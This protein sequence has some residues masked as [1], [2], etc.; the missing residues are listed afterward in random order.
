MLWEACFHVLSCNWRIIPGHYAV[1]DEGFSQMTCHGCTYQGPFLKAAKLRSVFRAAVDRTVHL[2]PWVLE[3][4]VAVTCMSSSREFP[5]HWAVGSGSSPPPD[6]VRPVSFVTSEHYAHQLCARVRFCLRCCL[7]CTFP[8]ETAW[9]VVPYGT[10]ASVPKRGIGGSGSSTLPFPFPYQDLTPPSSFDEVFARM[11]LHS[12]MCMGCFLLPL[13]RS[14]SGMVFL[15]LLATM[16]RSVPGKRT[17]LGSLIGL[18]FK[19]TSLRVLVPLGQVGVTYT[20]C[21]AAKGRRQMPCSLR[22]ATRG[23]RTSQRMLDPPPFR[24]AGYTVPE[25]MWAAP[26][27]LPQ[28]PFLASL[29][30]DMCPDEL[31]FQ[32]HSRRDDRAEVMQGSGVVMTGCPDPALLPQLEFP[33]LI[34]PAAREIVAPSHLAAPEEQAEPT[35]CVIQVFVPQ[36]MARIVTVHLALPVPLDDLQEEVRRDLLGPPFDYGFVLKPTAPQVGEGYVSLVAGGPW[37]EH[38]GLVVVV[39]DMQY[40]GGPTFADYLHIHADYKD[41]EVVARRQGLQ[42]WQAF[43]AGNNEKIR[44]RGVFRPSF[45]AVVQFR[46]STESVSWPSSIHPRLADPR[47]WSTTPVIAGEG[48]ASSALILGGEAGLTC[49]W[50]LDDETALDAVML[51]TFSRPRDCLTIV[52]PHTDALQDVVFQ[53]TACRQV[54]AV[55]GATNAACSQEAPSIV[56]IDPRQAG[57]QLCV[58]RTS[59]ASIS[60]SYLAR[61]A[62]IHTVPQGFCLAVLGHI[63]QEQRIPVVNGMLVILGFM[64]RRD[65][66]SSSPM[67]S[68]SSPDSDSDSTQGSSTSSTPRDGQDP[69]DPH[70]ANV[71]RLP[72]G[73]VSRAR[74]RTPRRDG[75]RCAL[76]SHS[77]G[78]VSHD[79]GKVEMYKWASQVCLDVAVIACRLGPTPVSLSLPAR[80]ALSYS[81]S[82]PISDLKLDQEPPSLTLEGRADIARLRHYAHHNHAP[83]PSLPAEDPFDTHVDRLPPTDLLQVEEPAEFTFGVLV[84]GYQVEVVT[85]QAVAPVPTGEAVELLALA[86]DPVMVRLFSAVTVVSPMPSQAFGLV[87]AL[88]WWSADVCL[89]LDLTAVDGRLYADVGPVTADKATLLRFVGLQPDSWVDIYL[90]S[91]AAPL[92]DDEIAVLLH[93]TCIFFVPRHELPGP[94]FHL[95]EVLLS[96]RSWAANPEI[97]SLQEEGFIC[98]VTVGANT[99]VDFLPEEPFAD[100]RKLSRIFGIAEDDLILQPAVPPVTDMAIRGR[101]CQGVYAISG[102]L[103]EDDADISSSALAPLLGLVDR[104]ALLQGWDLLSSHTGRISYTQF[105]EG[106]ETFM[107][108]SCM[109]HL[110]KCVHMEDVLVFEPGSVIFASYVPVRPVDAVQQ[111]GPAADREASDSEARTSDAILSDEDSPTDAAAAPTPD[112]FR[113]M[114]Q[115]ER[116]TTVS[117]SRSPYRTV[118][119]STALHVHPST[120]TRRFTYGVVRDEGFRALF[121]VFSPDF[122]PE[123]LTLHVPGPTTFRTVRSSLQRGRST[124]HRQRFPRLVAV[125]P[126]PVFE[127][128][129]LV[130]VPIWAEEPHLLFDCSQ[131]NGAIFCSRAHSPI[132]RDNLLAIAGLRSAADVE[133]YVHDLPHPLPSGEAVPVCTGFCVSL[134]PATGASSIVH[135]TDNRLSDPAGWASH[136]PLPVVP[137]FWVLVLTVTGPCWLSLDADRQRFLRQNVAQRLALDEPTY[138]LQPARPPIT[139]AFDCGMLASNVLIALAA[140]DCPG[141]HADQERPVLCVVDARPIAGGLTWL[142]APRGLVHEVELLEHSRQ[143]CPPGFVVRVTGGNRDVFGRLFVTAG[144]VLVLDFVDPQVSDDSDTSQATAGP[145]TD[146]ELDHDSAGDGLT[147]AQSSQTAEMSNTGQSSS[148]ANVAPTPP[149]RTQHNGL[150]TRAI[151]AQSDMIAKCWRPGHSGHTQAQKCGGFRQHS[152]PLPFKGATGLSWLVGILLIKSNAAMQYAHQADGPPSGPGGGGRPTPEQWSE[153]VQVGTKPSVS[154]DFRAATGCRFEGCQRGPVCNPGRQDSRILAV[155][156]PCRSCLADV[157]AVKDMATAVH[158]AGALGPTLLQESCERAQGRPLLEAAVLLETLFDHFEGALAPQVDGESASM[159]RPALSIEATLPVTPFQEDCLALKELIPPP[160]SHPAWSAS[161]DWLDRDID[162][163]IR[164]PK[165]PLDIRTGF[166][167]ILSWHLQGAPTPTRLEIFTDGSAAAT[168]E[169]AKPCSWAFTVWAIC[170]HQSLL[171]GCAA[172]AAAPTGTPYFIGECTQCAFTGE[173]LALCWALAWAIEFAAGFQAPL[174]FHYDARAAGEGVFGQC[175]LPHNSSPHYSLAET[176]VSLRQLAETRV[177]LSHRHVFGHSGVLGNELADQL[178]KR[179]RRFVE[180]PW[181]RCL[182][183]WVS[184]FAAHPLKLWAWAVYPTADTPCLFAFESEAGRLQATRPAAWPA[185]LAGVSQVQLPD[186]EMHFSLCVVSFNVLTLLDRPHFG[187]AMGVSHDEPEVGMKLLGR[188]EIVKRALRPHRPVIVG[189]QETRLPGDEV[190]VDHDYHI[191]AAGA[192]PRGEGGCALWLSKTVPF[193]YQ[194]GSPVYIQAKDVTIVSCSSRHLTANLVTDRLS[195]HLQVLHVPSA[196]HIPLEEV[197]QF[198]KARARELHNRIDGSEFIILADANARMG[199]LISR[200]V[201]GHDGE[202]E[203]QAGELMHTFLCEAGALA[204]STFA[205]YHRGESGTWRAPGGDW[206][207]I[208]YILIPSTWAKF[209][210]RSEVICQFDVMQLRDD[211]RPVKLC[212][213]FGKRAPAVSYARSCRCAVRP[214]KPRHT[215][216]RAVA[217][218]ALAVIPRFAWNMDVEEHCTALTKAWNRVGATFVEEPARKAKQTYLNDEA[219]YLIDCRRALQ[220]YLRA[221]DRER[222]RRLKLIAWAALRSYCQGL[223]CT[224]EA[225]VRARR[226]LSQ[227]DHSR[228]AAL[229][230]YRVFG[231]QLRCAIAAGKRSYLR[232][233]ASLAAQFGLGQAKELYGAIRRAFPTARSSRRSSL[234]PLPMLVDAKGASIV[235][236]EGRAECWRAHFA[237]QEAG[238]LATPEEYSARRQQQWSAR[239]PVFDVTILPTLVHTEQV[240]LKLKSDKAAGPDNLTAETLQLCVPDSARRLLPVFLKSTLGLREPVGWRGGDLVLLAKKAGKA[241]SCEGFRSVLIASVAGKTY[242]RCMRA[243]LLPLLS[244]D[245]PDFMAGAV[246]N[247]GIEV[248]VLAIRSFQFWAEAQRRPWSV[249]FF[250]LQSAYYSVLRQLVVQLDDDAASDVPLLSLLLQLGLPQQAIGELKDKLSQLAALPNLGAS[251]HL[252]GI[253]TDLLSGTWFRLSGWAA[254]TVTARG[255]RPGDPLADVLFSLTLSAY[256]KAVSNI[257][258]SQD[259][260]PVLPAPEERPHW[261][262]PDTKLAIGAPSWADDFALPQTGSTHGDLL[263]RTVRSVG[264]VVS[265]A[266]SIGMTIKFGRDKTAALFTASMV[267]D[268]TREFIRDSSGHFSVLVPDPVSGVQHELPVVASYRHLGGILTSNCSPIPDLHYRYAN[269]AGIVKPLSRKLFGAQG[270]DL[271]VRRTLLRALTLSRYVHTSASLILRA[272]VHNRVWDRHF[273]ALWR[274]LVPRHSATKQAHPYRVLHLARAVSPPLALAKSRAA[275]LRKIFTHGPAMLRTLLYDHWRSHPGSSWFSQ[276]QSDIG[277]IKQYHPNLGE[278]LPPHSEVESLLEAVSESPGWWL[279]KVVAA[280]KLFRKDLQE[281]LAQPS[282]EPEA[283]MEQHRAFQCDMCPCAFV[284]R[285]HLHAHQARAHRRFSP[286]R[287]YTYT[288]HCVSCLRF[289]GSIRQSQQHL[290]QSP[291]CLLR[292]AAIL[293]PLEYDRILSLEQPEKEAR[294]K[295]QRGQWQ[296]FAGCP[297]PKRVP[298]LFGPACPTFEE[299]EAASLTDEEQLSLVALRLY[300][301]TAEIRQ[302]IEDFVGG[303]SSEGRR[304]ATRRFWMRRPFLSHPNSLPEFWDAP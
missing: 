138:V 115:T 279:R 191:F 276:L 25:H 74:S 153:P 56:F 300:R 143:L 182:P 45:G 2:P 230:I 86:R 61:F 173:L 187:K 215:A 185:P 249:V 6:R 154:S 271:S 167:N 169:D 144:T 243:H 180:D 16:W 39:F 132:D 172:A 80:G 89:C 76:D 152:P 163:L 186:C 63:T 284:L 123:V 262:C 54:F 222:A 285:K 53:G 41:I 141:Q 157:P 98:V 209:E 82:P 245:M 68:P 240:I 297:P 101:H 148:S 79:A 4:E 170:G 246:E 304:A 90:G 75:R 179:A 247:I 260:L 125:E 119:L 218:E 217:A 66:D 47:Q 203:T 50:S 221:E 95:E 34:E 156:T 159:L 92:P 171:V 263:E 97:P 155:P 59:E 231:I 15:I 282:G 269:A 278:L 150:L 78:P 136:V 35:Q 206:H 250:D 69:D 223:P 176:A 207:R 140:E 29:T 23:V 31:P 288:E 193:A 295:V 181:C 27:G 212:C 8:G 24:V 30:R 219:L 110:E 257:L 204:P 133:V 253:I 301:P 108:P 151:L 299:R 264:V 228:A 128:V 273:L 26:Y 32:P 255:S 287:H 13:C 12:L 102:L 36:A 162:F 238:A 302:W 73:P 21:I 33:L 81:W 130:A 52:K 5:G 189:L 51:A 274:H 183:N 85:I 10:G 158:N 114:P 214:T 96:S 298:V 160:L 70:S 211:H 225:R 77:V 44:P 42:Q 248:P 239:E 213:S 267:R 111:E 62:G 117:R 235:T 106:L 281:W 118:S 28:L 84:P 135:S 188:R 196:A 107:P 57:C 190:Q 251:D 280:E 234:H 65:Q 58:T 227:I 241:L 166:V 60:V 184:A 286:A 237:S 124:E 265:H 20:A 131:I 113:P 261:A 67:S 146:P 14:L 145:D 72:T 277:Y 242:H 43:I 122:A 292:A 48:A 233:L 252:Q 201:G 105:R 259:L 202:E 3:L 220:D 177:P 168:A 149:G 236:S 195:L 244:S 290:K 205:A 55:V 91:S 270:F 296:A 216:D 210:P 197:R 49:P 178:A 192:G 46:R 198:W 200:S 38:R 88:P 126:Q 289:Y 64:P 194:N 7:S 40:V 19:G 71:P 100:T 293:P 268:T 83:W 199:S 1:S 294:L 134:I 17:P 112:A 93:G 147:E 275:F 129:A 258:A 303:K 283:P 9:P 142:G 103:P 174:A 116:A 226:W 165:V 87:I 208:D 11:L 137:G 272:A 224:S 256:L 229:A 22:L 161:V 175:A 164:D 139:D 291:A 232:S 121:A 104:R 254:L 109:V 266:R 120:G 18:P 127:Y 94:Y 99:G 37:L